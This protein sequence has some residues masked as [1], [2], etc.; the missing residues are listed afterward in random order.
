MMQLIMVRCGGSLNIFSI[1]DLDMTDALLKKERI[2]SCSRANII[3]IN[4]ITI[5]HFLVMLVSVDLRKYG[6]SL[7]TKY[8][9]LKLY[10]L[11]LRDNEMSIPDIY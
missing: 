9:F 8:K 10:E 5:I 11:Q 7:I 3:K 1:Q 6:N 2:I 4:A